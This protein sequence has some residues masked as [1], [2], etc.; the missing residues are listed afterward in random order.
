MSLK[1]RR[2]FVLRPA[3]L[4]FS[5]TMTSDA[6]ARSERIR[7]VIT[8]PFTP[9]ICNSMLPI[10]RPL[11]IHHRTDV[12]LW[13]RMARRSAAT[14]VIAIAIAGAAP[15]VPCPRTSASS[16]WRGI[17]I[18][19][20]MRRHIWQSCMRRDREQQDP[21]LVELHAVVTMTPRP[22]PIFAD[23]GNAPGVEAG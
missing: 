20:D 8:A 2:I 7:R 18:L 10:S 19:R 5:R 6:V 15:T 17:V 21:L 22:E 13:C 14:V 23:I 16:G 3:L 4:R 12:L 9:T 1:K 11:L